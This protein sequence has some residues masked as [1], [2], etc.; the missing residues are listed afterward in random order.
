MSG[1]KGN[2]PSK[3]ANRNSETSI[4][5]KAPRPKPEKSKRVKPAKE[6]PKKTKTPKAKPKAQQTPKTKPV[7]EKPVKGGLFSK[8][9]AKTNKSPK[10]KNQKVDEEQVKKF[11]VY[12][13]LKSEEYNPDLTIEPSRYTKLLI[14]T[15]DKRNV[16]GIVSVKEADSVMQDIAVMVKEVRYL[17]ED[18]TDLIVDDSMYDD[19]VNDMGVHQY[20]PK[21]KRKRTKVEVI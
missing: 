13:Y 5:D 18:S 2:K 4:Q 1:F 9:G 14:K 21:R 20:E 8:V 19:D 11:N 3:F 7:R 16:A 10:P 15:L 17:A 6:S 12:S